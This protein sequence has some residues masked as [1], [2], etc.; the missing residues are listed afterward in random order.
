MQTI[1]VKFS[2]TQNVL[3]SFGLR[4]LILVDEIKTRFTKHAN[5]RSI[6]I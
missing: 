6:H 5:R 1:F 2:L 3:S 4:K